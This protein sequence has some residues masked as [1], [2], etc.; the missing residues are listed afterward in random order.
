MVA[1]QAFVSSTSRVRH[2]LACLGKPDTMLGAISLDGT[3]M[4]VDE[5]SNLCPFGL[6]QHGHIGSATPTVM[7]FHKNEPPNTLLDRLF[8]VLQRRVSLHKPRKSFVSEADGSKLPHGGG[9]V[10]FSSQVSA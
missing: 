5:R 3:D 2:L 9:L 8:M 4:V 1:S 7:D 10:K 6:V